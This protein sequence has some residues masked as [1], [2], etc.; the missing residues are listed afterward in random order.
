ME[1]AAPNSGLE[2]ENLSATAGPSSTS[3][4][5]LVTS[6]PQLSTLNPQPPQIPDHEL[7][8][9]IGQGSYG[10]VWL[11]R[12]VMG[13]YRAVKMVHRAAF[14]GDSRPFEREFEGIR[15][16]EPISRSHE[17]QLPI[18]HVGLNEAAGCFYYVME[19]ADD[20]NSF[21]SV[22]ADVRRLT[23][24]GV[25]VSP[26]AAASDAR[27]ASKIS[28]RSIPDQS[29]AGEDSRAPEDRGSPDPQRV[30][31]EDGL[32]ES[33]G[34]RTGEAAAAGD[35]RAPKSEPPHVG[36][37]EPRTL[38]LELERHGRLPLAQ[39][40]DISLA[41][42]TA[43]AHLHKHGLV[44]RDIK[45]SNIIF[46]QGRPKLADIGL[47]TDAGDARS[48][49]GTEGYLAPEG[50][51]SPQADLYS[52]GKVL[53]EISTGRDRR[54]FPDLPLDLVPRS[55]ERGTGNAESPN[56]APLPT[57]HSALRTPRL[58]GL[59][60]LNEILLKACARDPRQRY[61]SAEAMHADL[62]LLQRG[63]SVKRQR[64]WERRW[65]LG[66]KLSL[67]SAGLV[68]LTVLGWKLLHDFELSRRGKQEA[69]RAD[70]PPMTGTTNL[71]AWKLYVR[72]NACF[73]QFT[74]EGEKAA[75]AHLTEAVRL[76]PNFVLAYNY[77]FAGY[78]NSAALAYDEAV[79]GM[80]TMAKRLREVNPDS[81][82][83]HYSQAFV[84]YSLD[85]KFAEADLGFKRALQIDPSANARSFYGA[86]LTRM[87][88]VEEARM[89]LR[90]MSDLDPASPVGELLL[91]S[92][93]YAERNHRQAL[94]HFQRARELAPG[95]LHAHLLMGRTHEAMG[96]YPGA[97]EHF[98]K[99]ELGSGK[100]PEELRPKYDALGQAVHESGAV[101]YWRVRLEQAQRQPNPEAQPYQMASILA[102]LGRQTEALDWL[103]KAL[104]S[105]DTMRNLLFDH[106]WDGLR[107][108]PRFQALLKTVGF[109]R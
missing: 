104:A 27:D 15:K 25:R 40:L 43:L 22:G 17:S 34:A 108:E 8:R 3:A 16:F 52:L 80:R 41:L 96:D 94:V 57:P 49:V 5:P 71:E 65:A 36:S 59:L 73:R 90:R 29:A 54:H 53:Y 75:R 26:P 74:I 35:N 106:Y 58:D 20:A 64:A 44:H 30:R 10:E 87:G 18:L 13:E 99:M 61:A 33:A 86:F 105:R 100:S 32:D 51:G 56:D 45:P 91:G 4:P 83:A 37:Y 48:I 93:Y 77:L 67:V 84:D 82:E 19:L 88:R 95:Y 46:V 98:Q 89:H 6:N 76:D 31:M 7:L 85:L 78:V 102:Q 63:Q 103:E 81:A 66:R 62:A 1:F 24:T 101:G 97:L 50:P 79:A 107:E 21:L 11:A 109:V 23:S 55:A 28:H 60:E 69:Q 70:L 42:T 38:R 39:C 68:V 12:N 9:R 2:A 72:G 14:G 47:V 92:T